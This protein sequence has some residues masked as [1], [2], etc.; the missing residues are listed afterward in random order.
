M[1]NDDFITKR[2]DIKAKIRV[3]KMMYDD[4]KNNLDDAKNAL[5][6][7]Y[8]RAAYDL[9]ED[10]RQ[11]I[12]T[13]GDKKIVIERLSGS[14]STFYSNS[15]IYIDIHSCKNFTIIDGNN[16]TIAR[17]DTP[18]QVEAVIEKFK[19]AIANGDNFF[20]CPTIEELP[21]D[22]EPF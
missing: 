16:N 1:I 15:D 19:E 10:F 3:E 22:E 4:A 2:D 21:T 5:R 8:K 6:K 14:R 7:L 20:I 17:Y 12:A 11:A 9:C 18:A 13:L